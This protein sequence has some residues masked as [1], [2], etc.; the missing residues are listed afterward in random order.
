MYIALSKYFKINLILMLSIVAL[1]I[2]CYVIEISRSINIE[3][4]KIILKKAFAK[5]IE[6]YGTSVKGMYIYSY[7]KNFL[8]KHALTTKLIITTNDNMKYK[9]VLGSL[10]YKAVLN[11][12]KECFGITEYKIYLEKR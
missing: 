8:K 4:N 2:I 10:N 5:K 6:L 1:L 11:L 12:M 9:F 3:N 7:N